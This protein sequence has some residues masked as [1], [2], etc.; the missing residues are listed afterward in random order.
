[1]HTIARYAYHR[2]TYHLLGAKKQLKTS[3]IQKSLSLEKK[4]LKKFL[5]SMQ[6]TG[7][8]AEKKREDR[9]SNSA[10]HNDKR[11]DRKTESN[12]SPEITDRGHQISEESG[13]PSGKEIRRSLREDFESIEH[14]RND[15]KAI[16][17]TKEKKQTQ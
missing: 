6:K 4:H 10:R 15:Q 1:M 2:L 12:D 5:E 16:N 17:K 14:R 8:K 3:A 11:A 7:P 13:L 9:R